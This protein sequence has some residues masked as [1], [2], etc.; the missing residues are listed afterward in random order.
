MKKN[1]ILL[2]CLL[3][4]FDVFSQQNLKNEIGLGV[5]SIE[6]NPYLENYAMRSENK[7]T[8]NT[9]FKQNTY[10]N[11]N[12]DISR[13]SNKH[14]FATPCIYYTNKATSRSSFRTSF[15]FARENGEVASVFNNEFNEPGIFKYDQK[16][17][18]ISLG[19]SYNVVNRK[20]LKVYVASDLDLLYKII[21]EN[22]IEYFASGCILNIQINEQV[23]IKRTSVNMKMNQLLGMKL[24]ISPCL[25]ATYELA[26]RL[27]ETEVR[28]RPMNRL[29][30]DYM[31]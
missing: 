21:Q 18:N 4:A 31:F 1:I 28:L 3:L 5:G 14:S 29:S 9:I 23:L 16:L 10:T 30:L 24:R 7:W 22:E 20:K 12:L 17:Y 26:G 25:N 11:Y 2:S 13:I 15:Q 6:L 8:F 27:I 19:Y